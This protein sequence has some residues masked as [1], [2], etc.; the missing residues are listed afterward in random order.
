MQPGLKQLI[1]QGQDNGTDKEADDAGEQHAANGAQEDHQ[2]G[3]VDTASH[4][5]R[6]QDVVKHHDQHAPD[7]EGHRSQCVAGGKDINYRGY[8]DGA[9]T[10]LHHG[11]DQAHQRPY[12]SPG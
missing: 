2:H 3:Y 8:H 11:G 4:E 10:D 12:A 7:Q 6:L 1:S 9:D 5:Q